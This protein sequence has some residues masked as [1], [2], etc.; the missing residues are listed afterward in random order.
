MS[1]QI[2]AAAH[3]EG[4]VGLGR[5]HVAVLRPVREGVAAVGVGMYRTRLSVGIRA[6]RGPWR[7]AHIRRTAAARTG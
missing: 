1:H 6:A 4:V 2:A 3:G 5:N 7:V